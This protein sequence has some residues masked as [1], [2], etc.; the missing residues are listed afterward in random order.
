MRLGKVLLGLTALLWT[1]YGTWLLVDPHGLEYAGFVFPHWSVTVEVMAMYGAFELMLGVFTWVAL[2][3]PDEFMRPAML[4]WA[5]LYTG[6][7]VARV[8]GILAWEG[9]F[10]VSFGGDTADAYNP[11][12]LFFL[13][14]PCAALFWWTL[15]RTRSATTARGEARPV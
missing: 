9:S 5:L 15:W 6:L 4:L 11:G 1:C 12:A 8:A 3:R 10:A 7:T 14:L 2:W 13:E